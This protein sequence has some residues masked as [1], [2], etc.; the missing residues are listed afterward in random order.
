MTETRTSPSVQC[1]VRFASRLLPITVI[2]PGPSFN[3][4]INFISVCILA[5]MFQFDVVVIVG[6]DFE[7]S[8]SEFFFSER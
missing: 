8:G 4:D 2:D 7:Q 5:R 6:L 3:A 1:L